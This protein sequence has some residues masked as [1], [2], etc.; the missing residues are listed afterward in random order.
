MTSTANQPWNKGKSRTDPCHCRISNVRR[1]VGGYM[2]LN[3]S[4][5]HPLG[6][7][8]GTLVAKLA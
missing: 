4:V 1:Y 3:K 2:L 7:A 8:Q 5:F 6:H